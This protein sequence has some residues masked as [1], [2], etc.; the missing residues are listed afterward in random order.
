[1]EFWI[2]HFLSLTHTYILPV[3]PTASNKN[4]RIHNRAKVAHG[5]PQD[6]Q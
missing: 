2:S 5:I 6:V 4:D 3:V 1:M